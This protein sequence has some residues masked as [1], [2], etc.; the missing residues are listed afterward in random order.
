MEINW[1]EPPPSATGRKGAAMDY[2]ALT[3]EMKQHPGRWALVSEKV[4]P[5]RLNPLK[6]RGLEVRT[7]TAG[8]GY[9][10]GFADLYARWP[11]SSAGDGA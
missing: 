3:A 7:V 5:G 8:L 4:T 2:D 1:K 6:R 11:E 10:R 9:E